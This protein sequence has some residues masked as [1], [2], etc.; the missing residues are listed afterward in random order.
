MEIAVAADVEAE[1]R[2]EVTRK[3]STPRQRLLTAEGRDGFSF[4]VLRSHYQGDDKAFETP[5][6][7]HGFQQVRWAER[8]SLN[9]APGEDVEEGDIGY[10]PRGTYY[11]PQL[12][13][14]GV[15][16]TLQ[17][18]FGNEM[19]GGKD[20]SRVYRE[21]VEKLRARG[22]IEDGFFIDVDPDTGKERRRDPTEAVVEEVTGS[23][24]TIPAEAYA[25]PILMHP[26]AHVYYAAG[27]G[28]EIKHLGSFYD[29]PGPNADLSIS[30]VRLSQGGTHRLGDDRAQL[31]WS[32]SPG[33]RVDGRTYPELT[34]LYS[35]LD[36]NVAV[37][38]AEV[39]EMYV[40][41]FP[42]LD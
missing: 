19:L 20:A 23:M 7:H 6:H 29:H 31:V 8:G 15:G 24:Y 33:L 12:R 35:P 40:I 30:M 28:V 27:P 37:T 14:H 36:E 4:R 25:A 3:G 26:K 13:D 1:V 16:I 22:R 10:F 34:F 21:G 32:I 38:C 9:F 39:V 2:G 41:E 17:F 42:R 18:G 5:R 11:G